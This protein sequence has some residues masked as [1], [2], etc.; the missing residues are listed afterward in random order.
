MFPPKLTMLHFLTTFIFGW[1]LLICQ[2]FA[3]WVISDYFLSDPIL[4][5]LFLPFALRLGISLHSK[6]AYF[7]VSYFAE[8]SIFLLLKLAY[9]ELALPSLFL[10]SFISLPILFLLSPYYQGNPLKKLLLQCWFILF[11]SLCNGILLPQYPFFNVVLITLSGGLLVVPAC[12]LINDFLF[13]QQW[14][15]ITIDF[16]HQ[17]LEL[18]STHIILY[19]FVFA[20]SIYTQMVL[21]N[22][23]RRFALFC[24]AIPIIILAFRY[25]WQGAVLGTILNSIA[26][27][28]TTHSQSNLEM[29]D[30]LLTLSAQTITG[31]FLGLGIQHQRN[32]NQHLSQELKRNQRLTRQLVHSEETVRKE[33]SRELHDEIGQNITAIRTQAMI[34]KRLDSHPKT[35]NS[36]EM[37]EQLSLNVYDTTK[38]LLNRIRPR[39]LDD[40]DL[41]QALK[42]LFLELNLIENGITP[43]LSWHN[44]QQIQLE[45]LLEITIYRLCQESLNNILKYAEATQIDIKIYI[46]DQIQLHIIDN[47]KGFDP[48]INKKGFGIQG[49][50][51]RVTILGG[52]FDLFSAPQQGTKIHIILPIF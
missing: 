4:S 43:N 32:L 22:E 50:K 17:P 29:I 51:E 20:L 24:L 9:P 38:G 34:L 47:G 44:P 2:Y 26:I 18:R 41:Q 19:I 48:T 31:L 49:M 6:K 45:H 40:L 35:Q 46:K 52:E 37:I 42:N 3:F 30:V 27:I 28:A 12:Y 11:I 10:L 1:F 14:K 13:N 39:L 25:G 21:P 8:W 7:L 33:I 15:T 36:A 23:F 16:I 5:F